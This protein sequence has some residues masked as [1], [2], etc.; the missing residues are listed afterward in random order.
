VVGIHSWVVNALKAFEGLV[1]E[2][3]LTRP[4]SSMWWK[5]RQIQTLRRS[6]PE[7]SKRAMFRLKYL[8]DR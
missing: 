5:I 2:A 8:A 3:R 1:E 6:P 7:K 4:K